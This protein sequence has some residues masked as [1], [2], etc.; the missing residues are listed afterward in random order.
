M[1]E[2]GFILKKIIGFWLMPLS[3]SV[4]LIALG[5]TLIWLNRHI[6]TGKI[7]ATCGLLFLLI[8]SWQPS[9]HL[10]LS[11]IESA[12]PKF[13]NSAVDYIV[14]LGNAVT[15][16]ERLSAI[17]Q[18]SNSARARLFEGVRIAKQQPQ[19]KLILSGYAG[20]NNRSCAE[21][22]SEAAISLGI[23]P[24]RIITLSE[25]KD[26]H[27]EAVAVKAIVNDKATAL[28]TS[29][30]HMQRAAYYFEQ[31]GINV[32]SAPTFYLAKGKPT[33]DWRFNADGL[34]QSERAIHERIGQLWQRLK[35]SD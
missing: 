33:F 7:L 23:K 16:D 3:I 14:V 21:V 29:A 17:E 2:A 25:P 31:A 8:F 22:Y 15:S 10:L 6:K 20:N 19:S 35:S 34:Y 32:I 30:S 9:S 27:D 24:E 26:T 5:L 12:Y 28:V 1:L 4:T 11:P 18:L 13:N